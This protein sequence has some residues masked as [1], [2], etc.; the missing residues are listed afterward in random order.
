[1]RGSKTVFTVGTWLTLNEDNVDLGGNPNMLTADTP[2][3]AGSFAYNTILVNI[4]KT[5]LEHKPG[6]DDV[7]VSRAHIFRRDQ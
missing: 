1:M 6:W 7:D 3:P 5:D 2:S 4:K